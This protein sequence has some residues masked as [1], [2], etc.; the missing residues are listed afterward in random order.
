MNIPYYVSNGYLVFS[1][2]IYYTRKKAGESIYN[3]VVSAVQNLI[4]KPYVNKEH[5]GM[6]GHSF[7]WL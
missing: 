3:F 5:I 2:D 4:R 6:Q 1:P 7:E